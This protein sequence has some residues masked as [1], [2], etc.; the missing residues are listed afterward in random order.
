MCHGVC[1]Y[2]HDVSL[3][4]SFTSQSLRLELTD[5]IMY[6]SR[7]QR[8]TSPEASLVASLR[9]A[10][11]AFRVLQRSSEELDSD[12]VGPRVSSHALKPATMAATTRAE[13]EGRV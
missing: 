4:L 3:S 10:L 5:C 12:I 13:H 1:V 7:K 8:E 2:G 9:L 6:A 11:A